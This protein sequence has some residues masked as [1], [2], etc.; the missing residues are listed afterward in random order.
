MEGQHCVILFPT[1]GKGSGYN[2]SVQ[3]ASDERM[4]VWVMVDED[5]YADQA[6]DGWI[7]RRTD[8]M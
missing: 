3:Q 6:V 2:V 4:M 1:P 5:G 7:D 8:Y